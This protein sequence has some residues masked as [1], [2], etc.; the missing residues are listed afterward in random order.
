MKIPSLNMPM[1]VRVDIFHDA[2]W[3]DALFLPLDGTRPRDLTGRNLELTILPVYNYATP[4]HVLSSVGGGPGGI[5]IDAPLVGGFSFHLPKITI[6]TLPIGNWVHVFDLLDG[7]G[8]EE[9]WRGP[10]NINAGTVL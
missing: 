9:I 2:D 10:F 3:S 4:I 8:R 6:I 1:L 7:S 5:T